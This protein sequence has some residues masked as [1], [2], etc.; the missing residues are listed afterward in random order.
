MLWVA[1]SR[2]WSYQSAL[3][4]C[5]WTYLYPKVSS[6]GSPLSPISA[7]LGIMWPFGGLCWGF[8]RRW[9]RGFRCGCRVCPQ[10]WALWGVLWR[11]RGGWVCARRRNFHWLK[12]CFG[13]S[14]DPF[15]SSCLAG[16]SLGFSRSAPLSA[17]ST[18]YFCCAYLTEKVPQSASVGPPAIVTSTFASVYY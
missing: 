6:S 4:C 9:R 18:P 2:Q 11:R 14:L 1:L 5:I 12:F 3:W 7:F 15:L 16:P 8:G 17:P 10:R 13:A